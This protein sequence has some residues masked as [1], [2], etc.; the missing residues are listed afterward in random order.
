MEVT[1][2]GKVY[3]HIHTLHM[4]AYDEKEIDEQRAHF[5]IYDDYDTPDE[6]DIKK[7]EEHPLWAC[8]TRVLY[9]NDYD[10]EDIK[11]LPPSITIM[12]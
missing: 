3:T 8:T 2:K 1:I 6:S 9:F 4:T 7:N 12:P 10:L 5:I 11:V